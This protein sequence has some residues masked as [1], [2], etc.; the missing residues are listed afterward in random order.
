MVIGSTVSKCGSVIIEPVKE[1]DFNRFALKMI[2]DN[3]EYRI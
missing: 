1:H 3:Y 2:G